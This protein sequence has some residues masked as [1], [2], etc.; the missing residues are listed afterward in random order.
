MKTLQV[1]FISLVISAV[2]AL[3]VSAD[4]PIKLVTAD[5]NRLYENYYR[6]AEAEARFQSA[7]EA[8]QASAEAMMAEGNALVEEYRQLVEEASSPALSA[9]ARERA[10]ASAEA[11]LETIREKEREVQQFQANTQR[12]LQQRQQSHRQL[13]LDEIGEVVA[14]IG[15]EKGATLVL[16]SSPHSGVVF[17]EPAFDITEESLAELN[18][19]QP[20]N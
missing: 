2:G 5:M 14:A 7:V 11:K 17:A 10:E 3:T 18:R 16:D 1:L 19:D 13:V 4:T 12:A 6:T 9:E 20:S 8:A 15:R